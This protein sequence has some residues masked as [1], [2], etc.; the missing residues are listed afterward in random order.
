MTIKPLEFFKVLKDCQVDFFTGVPDSLLKDLCG[1][2]LDIVPENRHVI[3]A[4]EGNAIALAC[5]YHLGTGRTPLVYMQNSG[6][7]NA[8]NPLQSLCDRDVYAIPMILLVG[9]RGMPGCADEPQHTKTGR[10]QQSLLKAM[11]LPFE[12]L[13]AAEKSWQKI[14]EQGIK[15]G[16]RD[17]TPF[18]FLVQKGTFLPHKKN[19]T[20]TKAYTLLREEALQIILSALDDSAVVVSTTGKTSREIFELRA[21]NGQSHNRD[22]L[23]IGSMGHCSS[24]AAGLALASPN[25]NIICIDGDAALIMHMGALAINGK[26]KQKNFRH[27]LINNGAHESVGGQPTVAFELDFSSLLKANCYADYFYAADAKELKLIIGEF[28]KA[29]GP[30][31]LEVKVRPGSRADLGRPTLSPLEN[32]RDFMN[33]LATKKQ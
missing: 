27:I 30:V 23:S 22:F 2:F 10:T 28:L 11:E 33:F 15:T 3:A 18:V 9:W 4:N 16:Q 13:N 8:I 26:L 17:A 19:S 24:I 6:L 21:K 20:A 1:C 12:I 14:V 25:K 5:G 7:G 29:D 32:K 31:F